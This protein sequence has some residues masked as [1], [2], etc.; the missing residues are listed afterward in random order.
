MLDDEKMILDSEIKENVSPS[1]YEKYETKDESESELDEYDIDD[2]VSINSIALFLD[3]ITKYPIYSIEEEVEAFKRYQKDPSQANKN[4]IAN[5]N[6]RLVIN[7]AKKYTFAVTHLELL[8]LVQIGTMGLMTAIEKFDIEKGYKFSTYATFWIKQAITRGIADYE[9]TIRIPVHLHEEVLKYN[10]FLEEYKFKNG[11]YPDDKTI[12]KHLCMSQEKIDNIRNAAILKDVNSLNIVIGENLHQEDNKL[13]DFI[14]DTVFETPE[15][16]AQR[17]ELEQVIANYIE[18]YLMTI[19]PKYRDRTRDIIRHRYGFNGAY[20]M[21]LEELSKKYGVT[22]E[23][24][25]QIESFFNRWM[26]HPDRKKVL[27]H[28]L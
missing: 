6:L 14:E 16:A 5:H 26:A 28:Y 7:I 10:K 19:K 8:D 24:I 18:Q 1:S 25:R 4:E 2:N 17:T 13:I 15:D 21:T 23:R 20:P 9:H 3:E 12:R 11:K 27:I 22:R